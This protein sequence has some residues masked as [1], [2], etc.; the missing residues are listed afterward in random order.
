MPLY[1]NG[2]TEQLDQDLEA[3]QSCE[4]LIDIKTFVATWAYGR[5]QQMVTQPETID[6]ENAELVAKLKEVSDAMG[7][8]EFCRVVQVGWAKRLR[9]MGLPLSGAL[10]MTFV[11]EVINRYHEGA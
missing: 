2:D 1:Y 9:G 4:Y 6:Y 3:V 7:H 11:P 5:T 8:Q 10:D